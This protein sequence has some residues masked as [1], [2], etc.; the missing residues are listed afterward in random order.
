M[1]KSK[2]K[3]IIIIINIFVLRGTNTNSILIN[4]TNMY[5]FIT[6]FV[7]SDG[8]VI[9][10]KSVWSFDNNIKLIIVHGICNVG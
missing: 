9:Y 6:I 5:R 2:I 4:D 7:K 10:N 8:L 1:R 3:Y